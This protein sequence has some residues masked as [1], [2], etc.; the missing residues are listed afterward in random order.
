MA[1]KQVQGFVPR[2]GGILSAASCSLSN[3]RSGDAVGVVEGLQA[4]LASDAVSAQI[5]RIDGVALNFLGPALHYS[6]HQPLGFG[7]LAADGCVPVVPAGNQVFGQLNG[8]LG[9]ELPL[10]KE[11]ARHRPQRGEAGQPKEISSCYLH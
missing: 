10:V 6:D 4:S 9:D 2:Y 3:H 11:V 5:G 7:A 1:A 8:A